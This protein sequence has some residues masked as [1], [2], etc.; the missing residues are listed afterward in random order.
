MGTGKRAAMFP[1]S[2]QFCV[3]DEMVKYERE[4][5]SD[6][7]ELPAST[8]WITCITMLVTVLAILVALL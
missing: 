4:L 6:R 5:E 8:W 7:L 3:G 1:R 2:E